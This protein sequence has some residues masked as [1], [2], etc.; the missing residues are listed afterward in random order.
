MSNIVDMPPIVGLPGITTAVVISGTAIEL[1]DSMKYKT[2]QVS[3]AK[4]KNVIIY[5]ET[6][7]MRI[8]YGAAPVPATPFG[9]PIVTSKYL[10]LDRWEEINTIQMI[11]NASTNVN[12]TVTSYF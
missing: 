12:L 5:V 8:A 7:D 2:G 9:Y 10:V 11:R 6:A 4:A 3:G 1:T